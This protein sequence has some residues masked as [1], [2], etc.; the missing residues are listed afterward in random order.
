V[1]DREVDAVEV[2]DQDAEAEQPRDA[3]SAAW[4][5]RLRG[6]DRDKKSLMAERLGSIGGA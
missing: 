6:W 5:W 2:V 1:R 3:P 4:D